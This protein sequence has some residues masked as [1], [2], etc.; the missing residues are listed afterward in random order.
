MICGCGVFF[1]FIFPHD[2]VNAG[3]SRKLKMCSPLPVSPVFNAQFLY[4]LSS[5]KE[6]EQILNLA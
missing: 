1:S 3:V 6:W 5:K 2:K 4:S